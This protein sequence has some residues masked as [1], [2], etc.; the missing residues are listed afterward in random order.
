MFTGH[1]LSR[2]CLGSPT[3]ELKDSTHCAYSKKILDNSLKLK[4]R[5]Y[6]NFTFPTFYIQSHSPPYGDVQVTFP[7]FY[8]NSKWPP[9]INFNFFVGAKTQNISLVIFFL[10][11]NVTFLA[12]WGCVS[13]FLKILPKFKIAVRG[14]LQFFLCSRMEIWRFFLWFYS[15]S[16]CAAMNELH[17]CLWAQRPPPQVDFL[18]ICERKKLI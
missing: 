13:V 10:N 16:K 14:Q 9:R 18:N 11:F 12:T 15:N 6:S 2:L 3:A 17:I 8:W 1:P 7:R 5:N 4:V